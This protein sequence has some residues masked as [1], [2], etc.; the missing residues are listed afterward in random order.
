[1]KN[2]NAW[3]IG[4]IALVV[5][6]VIAGYVLMNQK[7]APVAPVTP[8]AAPTG[9][10]T[11]NVEMSDMAFNPASLTIK[12]GDSVAWTNK[13]DVSHLI[14]GEGGIASKTISKDGSY[15]KTFDKAGTYT[16]MCQIH[17]S[18]K[19]TIVVE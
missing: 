13:D 19:G 8:P 16:Y 14:T 9:P 1:M 11:L 17:P 18:M 6:A 15:S 5:I 3:T 4:I 10:Q 12:V 2:Q 7:E